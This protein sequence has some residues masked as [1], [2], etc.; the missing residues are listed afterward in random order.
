M[1]INSDRWHL[2]FLSLK[3]IS[4][5]DTVKKEPLGPGR[6]SVGKCL[7]HR[8]E[9][10]TVCALPQLKIPKFIGRPA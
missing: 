5:M 1:K 3:D 7:L 9:G 2:D 6:V 8:Q 10:K 4:E